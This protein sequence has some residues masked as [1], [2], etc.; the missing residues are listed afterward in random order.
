MALD[1]CIQYYSLNFW[2]WKFSQIMKILSRELF[3]IIC[4]FS[5]P[6]MHSKS[7]W[8]SSAWSKWQRPTCPIDMVASKHQMP[9]CMHALYMAGRGFNHAMKFY[10]RKLNFISEQNWAKY[11]IFENF[12]LYGMQVKIWCRPI[13]PYNCYLLNQFL[14]RKRQIR[15][16]CMR[17]TSNIN[18]CNIK[19]CAIH[20]S[21]CGSQEKQSEN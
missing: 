2:G 16:A 19:L 6:S 3:S 8:C 14:S 12:R 4:G 5:Q 7:S 21:E 11:L 13:H 10:P 9:H 20:V 15:K 17:H 1:A 18:F